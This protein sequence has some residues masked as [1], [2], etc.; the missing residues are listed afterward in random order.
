MPA[1][2]GDLRPGRSPARWTTIAVVTLAA[3]VMPATAPRAMAALSQA[4]AP[5]EA[6]AA[7]ADA[8]LTRAQMA[9][10]L[11]QLCD[12]AERAWAY[13]DDRREH[14]GVD[15]PALRDRHTSALPEQATRKEFASVLEELVAALEDGHA[16]V[17]VPGVVDRDVRFWPCTLADTTDGLVIASVTDG[18][19]GGG[20]AASALR[21]GD[22]VVSVNGEG[23]E[24]AIARVP[25]R[26][27][28]STDG[29]RRR[30]ALDRLQRTA[31]ATV[32]LVVRDPDAPAGTSGERTLVVPTTDGSRE[33]KA[34]AEPPPAS[35]TWLA[36][37]VACLRVA[38]FGLPD[39]A[40]FVAASH[41]RQRE[42]TEEA[43]AVL[44]ARVAE[45]GTARALVVDLRGNDGGTDWLGIALA[46]Q[47]L[48]GRFLYFRLQTR[49]SPE[50]A[51]VMPG[52]PAGPGW[53][54]AGDQHYGNEG[55]A[56]AFGGRVV[57]L[58]DEDVF[59]TA[60][61]FAAAVAD[62]HPDRVVVGRPTH[63]G[64][65]APRKLVTLLHS[66]AEITLT[67]MKVWRASGALIEGR[68]TQPDVLVRPTR[69]DVLAGRDPD[70]EAALA[71]ARASR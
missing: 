54:P 18:G 16:W 50:A 6:Q 68:G 23:L 49:Y 38:T 26:T 45:A 53:G 21:V 7:P 44:A 70:I 24:D 10:D 71:A 33:W 59:S 61:N 43:K 67:T 27:F 55:R 48:P 37:D 42:L 8:T 34:R 66:G 15:L 32:T 56:P 30:Q 31:Q 57:L 17:A 1:A 22:V 25:R 11:A 20:E 2:R 5:A 4:A 63:G 51:A 12:V 40:A 65:G 19:A 64:S 46:E 9:A 28:A 29:A 14:F 69:A 35:L 62:Q 60:D 36:D 39:F 52:I 41:E 58:I 3:L 47:L 13:A